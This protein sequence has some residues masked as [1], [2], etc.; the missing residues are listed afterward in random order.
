MNGVNI[1]V[2][3]VWKKETICCMDLLFPVLT[4]FLLTCCKKKIDRMI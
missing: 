3:N 2:F 4:Q 1:V